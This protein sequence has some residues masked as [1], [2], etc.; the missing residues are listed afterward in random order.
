MPLYDYLCDVC[1][2]RG[3]S[4]ASIHEESSHIDCP[5]CN[6]PEERE[7]IATTPHTLAAPPREPVLARKIITRFPGIAHGMVREAHY[8]TS[9][10][11]VVSSD[12]DFRSELSR[13]SDA[14][15]ERN[16]FPVQFA[17]ID[18]RESR[19]HLGVTDEG[20]ESTYSEQVK[21]GKRDVIK[22]F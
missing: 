20:L 2:W 22:H 5:R 18:H 14:A 7:R 3:E 8:N 15:S 17:P 9:V 21:Q 4:Y 6:H 1:G 13:A 16:G 10:G 11:K 12:A 19:D